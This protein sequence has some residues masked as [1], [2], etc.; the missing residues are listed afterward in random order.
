M[1]YLSDF[2]EICKNFREVFGQLR[3]VDRIYRIV[4]T[5]FGHICHVMTDI[6]RILPIFN[7]SI[8][9]YA[10]FSLMFHWFYPTSR[11]LFKVCR[12]FLRLMRFIYLIFLRFAKILGNFSDNYDVLPEFI[13]YFWHILVT[14]AML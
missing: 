11:T 13:E 7:G 2:L 4:L 9:N 12:F 6:L 3:C 8:E 5:H 14:S 10:V 1:F